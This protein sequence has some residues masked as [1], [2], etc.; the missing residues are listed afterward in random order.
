MPGGSTAGGWGILQYR[1]TFA[2]DAVLRSTFPF[3]QPPSLAEIDLITRVVPARLHGLSA[4]EHVREGTALVLALARAA[5][6]TA[7]AVAA[8]ESL[9]ESASAAT[10]S[11]TDWVG[12]L[13]AAAEAYVTVG[14][15]RECLRVA[16]EA[17]SYAELEGE[18]AILFRAHL[19]IALGSALDGDFRTG[20]AA[21]ARC[22]ELQRVHAWPTGPYLFGL[23]LAEAILASAVFDIPRLREVSAEMAASGPEQPQWVAAART[24][25]ALAFLLEGDT[26]ATIAHLLPVLRSAPPGLLEMIRGFALILNTDA[27]LSR[28]EAYRTLSL[29]RDEVAPPSHVL[30]FASQRASAHLLLNEDRQVLIDTDECIALGSRHCNRTWAP[31]LLRRAIALDRLGH[32]AA[33]DE[34]FAEAVHL[35]GPCGILV[36]FLTLPQL[37]LRRLLDRFEAAHPAG[38][39]IDELRTQLERMPPVDLDRSV[40]PKLTDREALVA[41]RLRGDA[42][43]AAIAAALHVSPNTVKTQLRSLYRK[44]EV[45]TRDDAV[46]ALQ[47]HGFYDR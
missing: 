33:A 36:P 29:L 39:R 4:A 25:E 22:R 26:D 21:A 8:A 24:M 46:S 41:E 16:R 2:V 1:L 43:V 45:N 27:L 17:L 18:D 37:P 12:M 5:R 30:C 28:G 32:I 34:H 9:M 42:S 10:V 3:G 38:P 40:L 31:V 15:A 14:E 13:T 19:F 7:S 20:S 47:E 35:V 11:V 6:P 44:L 23:L